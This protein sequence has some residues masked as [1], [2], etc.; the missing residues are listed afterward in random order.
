M[1]TAPEFTAATF[2]ID[3]GTV[4]NRMQRFDANAA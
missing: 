1:Q 2:L 3:P 4:I